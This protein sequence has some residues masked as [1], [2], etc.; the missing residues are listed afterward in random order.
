MTLAQE[1]A[2]L[3]KR[4]A[5]A[6]ASGEPAEVLAALQSQVDEIEARMALPVV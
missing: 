3:R 2:T 6:V 5:A 4:L 1:L